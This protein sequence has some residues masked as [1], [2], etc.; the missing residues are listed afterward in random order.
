M[1][2]LKD[3][4]SLQKDGFLRDKKGMIQIPMVMFQ[5][6]FNSRDDTL[7][8]MN[9]HVSYPSVSKYSKKHRYDKFS[10]MTGTSKPVELYDVVM[11]I[12]LI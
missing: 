5:K 11:L 1:V 4:K 2:I 6:K 9:R 10:K 3:G 8:L 7:S 12:M